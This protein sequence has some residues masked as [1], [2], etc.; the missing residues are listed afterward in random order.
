M[1]LFI[2]L[3]FILWLFFG[4]VFIRWLFVV[5]EDVEILA[6]LGTLVYVSL[7]ISFILAIQRW[8]IICLI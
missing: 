7:T 3:V 6:I 4:G 2:L 1:E 5:C 8:G